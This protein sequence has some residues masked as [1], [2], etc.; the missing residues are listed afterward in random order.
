MLLRSITLTDFGLF[1]GEQKIPLAPR[2][3]G[4]R[5]RPIVLIGGKNG[6]GK[7][8]LLEALRLTLYGKLALGHRVSHAEYH[9]Y[10]RDRIHAPPGRAAAPQNAAI[11]VDFDYS[12]DGETHRYVVTRAWAARGQSVVETLEIEKD[13]KGITSIPRD[14]WHFFLQDLLPPGVS[15]LFFFDGEKIKE[16]ADE[17]DTDEHLSTAIRSLLGIEIVSRLR[18]DLGLYISRQERANQDPT[19]PRLEAVVRDHERLSAELSQLR[20]HLADMR[21]RTDGLARAADRAKRR[22]VSAG[23][24]VSLKVGELRGEREHLQKRQAALAARI[25]EG[26]ADLWPLTAAPRLLSNLVSQVSA[27]DPNGIR[28]ACTHIRVAFARWFDQAPSQAKLR[29][30]SGAQDDLDHILALVEQTVSSSIHPEDPLRLVPNGR[31]RLER[32]L[33]Q[34]T[35]EA[36]TVS[37]EFA[38]NAERIR[39]IDAALARVDATTT[40]F[41]LDE[42]RSSEQDLGSAKRE[43]QAAE[44]AAKDLNYRLVVLNRERDRILGEQADRSIVDRRLSLASRASRVLAEYEFELVRHKTRA[45]EASFVDCFNRLARKSDVVRG[46]RIDDDTFQV[47]LIG[48]DGAEIPKRQLSAGEKQI[49]AIAILWALAKTSGRRLPVIIDTPLARLDS[50]HRANII[51]RYLPEVSHQ[52][53]VLSTDTEVDLDVVE[54]L[55]KHISHSFLL[56]FVKREGRTLVLPGYFADKKQSMGAARAL[57]QA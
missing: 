9:A 36:R 40:D 15:Q 12:E 23:G 55:S 27:P 49:Y 10:L 39:A 47:T 43:L 44:E 33:T 8:T 30:S 48:A 41:L 46:V 53:V 11:S 21:T 42:L 34:A 24:E 57:Q 51:G 6:A 16:I 4:K 28:E 25:K 32:A 52:V 26:S 29:W 14:E 18:T 17:D 31:E 5:Q 7:T 1:A 3:R 37:E 56:D 38:Q 45:L 54:G 50:E 35:S 2:A 13:G 19:T 22:F 20:D